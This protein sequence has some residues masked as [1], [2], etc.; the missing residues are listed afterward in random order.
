MQVGGISQP[1]MDTC[2]GSAQVPE[3][4]PARSSG[5]QGRATGKVAELPGDT[6]G[7]AK[8]PARLHGLVRSCSLPASVNS[9]QGLRDFEVAQPVRVHGRHNHGT[10]EDTWLAGSPNRLGPAP[11]F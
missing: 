11:P 4:L 10:S 6:D 9:C 3:E 8:C 5:Q 1:G 2:V 7:R